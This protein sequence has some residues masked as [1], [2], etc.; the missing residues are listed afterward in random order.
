VQRLR[1]FRGLSPRTRLGKAGLVVGVLA[2]L[3]ATGVSPAWAVPTDP[4][5]NP[6]IS[7]SSATLSVSPR[8]VTVGQAVTFTS[9]VNKA[10]G[11]SFETHLIFKD[12]TT[13]G[14]YRIAGGVPVTPP[15]SGTYVLQATSLGRVYD[16]ASASVTA[17]LPV[18]N[19]RPL[20]AVTRGGEQA[21]LFALGARTANA[22]VVI[23]AGVE[24]DLSYLSELPVKAGVTIIGLRDAAHAAGPRL[25]TQSFPPR[26]LVVGTPAEPSDNVRITGIR[27][28][29][30]ES[31]DPCDSA[32]ND[33]P[34]T[35]AVE[36]SS[37]RGVDIGENEFSRWPGSAV[38]IDD[39]G[40]RLD[41]QHTVRVHDNYIHHNQHPTYCGSDPTANGGLGL[42]YGVVLGGGG[43]AL[44][45]SNEFDSNRHAIAGDGSAGTGYLAYR[46]LFLAPGLNADRLGK[47]RYNSH[48][49]M[50]GTESCNGENYTCGMAGE[51]MDV[52]WNTVANPTQAPPSVVS[53]GIRL[54]GIPT[55][56]RGMSVH[57]NV[58]VMGRDLALAETVSGGLHDD[59]RNS[60]NVTRLWTTFAMDAADP[61]GGTCDFDHDGVKDAF[62]ATG[63]TWW[64]Y[65]SLAH[66]YIYLNQSTLISGITLADVNGDGL[67]DT[68]AGGTVKQTASL[69][70]T[71]LP[72]TA[73][74]PVVIGMREDAAADALRMNGFVVGPST[75]QPSTAA[76]GTV[77]GGITG[78]VHQF[79]TVFNL[80]VS[81]GGK[82]V[83]SLIGTTQATVGTVLTNAGLTL[84]AI[85]T[86]VDPAA[87]GTVV[88]Q[89]RAPDTVLLPGTAVSVTV[90]LGQVSVP[91][92]RSTTSNA[93]TL[94][95]RNAGLTVTV[96]S[97]SS[98]L[99]PG[100][101]SSQNPGAG[102]LVAPGTNVRISV[103]VCTGNGGNDGSGNP[104]QPL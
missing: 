1:G 92:V 31:D 36:I 95:L 32:G 90:S 3:G 85:S 72:V 34:T 87:P 97:V 17:T 80:I 68:S 78:P 56:A 98:C 16:M 89:D 23:G 94:T 48:L 5:D 61:G 66:R 51:F 45:E 55:D 75:T 84:G 96:D 100:R 39:T 9:S 76:A 101:V 77:L 52:G 103:A 41:A 37:S 86:R 83:P 73:V 67:C 14:S 4:T 62:Q 11:C 79:G 69:F 12:A 104:H 57:D 7:N 60:F 33:G 26:L 82:T 27:F 49:D 102:A 19:G 29:G 40:G 63:A 58:F 2:V 30:G 71:D 59:G 35:R 65:S 6:C 13:G 24:L 74:A 53:E 81:S 20:A 64:Y 10:A 25:S 38:S 70:P 46:N 42:G 22:L 93:A 21:S 8:S 50:H 15:S 91:E 99:D 44:I 54:R 88:A 43:F 28:E 18:V 47:H